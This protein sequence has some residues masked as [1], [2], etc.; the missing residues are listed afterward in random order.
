MPSWASSTFFTVQIQL[1]L[2]PRSCFISIDIIIPYLTLFKFQ[3]PICMY[4]VHS[5]GH[6]MMF[7]AKNNQLTPKNIAESMKK[8]SHVLIP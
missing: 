4:G 1:L 2:V 5:L 8:A 6:L 3:I 7:N